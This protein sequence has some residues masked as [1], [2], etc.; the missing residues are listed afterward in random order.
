MWLHCATSCLERHPCSH[1]LHAAP[2][3]E[4][5]LIQANGY[6]SIGDFGFAAPFSECRKKGPCGTL[7]YQAPELLNK[8]PHGAP[9]DWWALGCLLFEMVTSAS[10]FACDDDDAT[11]AAILGHVAGASLVAAA[12]R[13]TAAAAD[14]ASDAAAPVTSPYAPS[15]QLTALCHGLLEPDQ[16]RRLGHAEM[17]GVTSIKSHGWFDGF[18]WEACGAMTAPAPHTPPPL[19]PNDVDGSLLELSRRCQ[20]G[21]G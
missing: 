3:P 19:D 15:A 12:E 9:V 13:R 11:E 17:G 5:L 8:Q 18:D 21:F 6:L 10:P 16:S 4:N 20:Q 7:I 14:A 1:R 2:Q